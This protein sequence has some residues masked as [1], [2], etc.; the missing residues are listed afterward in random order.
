MSD[1]QSLKPHSASVSERERKKASPASCVSSLHRLIFRV[2]PTD[3]P[4]SWQLPACHTPSSARLKSSAFTT[5]AAHQHSLKTWVISNAGGGNQREMSNRCEGI[6]AP[7][8]VITHVPDVTGMNGGRMK[9]ER[10][11]CMTEDLISLFWVLGRKAGKGN[12]EEV[13]CWWQWRSLRQISSLRPGANVPR[14]DHNRIHLQHNTMQHMEKQ[15]RLFK[16]HFSLPVLIAL[17][18]APLHSLL[19]QTTA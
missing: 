4:A 8:H 5:S 1:P 7:K 17:L 3:S 10:F 18:N 14:L 9:A 19:M 11:P 6:T 12:T 15:K 2:S 13:W 16:Q